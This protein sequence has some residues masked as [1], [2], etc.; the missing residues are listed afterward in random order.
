MN[1][2][3]QSLPRLSR[4]RVTR[5][6]VIIGAAVT[7]LQITGGSSSISNSWIQL[8]KAGAAARAMFVAAASRSWDVPSAEI[9]VRNGI[10]SHATSG[11]QASFGELLALAARES[12]PA[13][14]VLKPIAEFTLLGT[15]RLKRLDA[16]AKST[17]AERY[18]VDVRAPA[19]LTALVAHS[20]RFGGKVKSFDAD[21]AKGVVDV[22]EIPSGVAVIANGFYAG[23]SRSTRHG[24]AG[25]PCTSVSAR[26]SRTWPRCDSSMGDRR[27]GVWL[28]QSIAVSQ[29]RPIRCAPKWKAASATVCRSPCSGK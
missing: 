1:A 6:Q 5:R 14:P 22:F 9:S 25:L 28:S 7:K 26:S 10:V 8:R 18:T 2:E 12:A 17:G 16:R 3:P 27:Y 21:A 4:G 29:S 13:D 20:P 23:V 11:R 15:S 19:L 24:H